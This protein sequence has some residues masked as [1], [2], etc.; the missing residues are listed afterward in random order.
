MQKPND[1]VSWIRKHYPAEWDGDEGRCSAHR[2]RTYLARKGADMYYEKLNQGSIA[3]WR[4]RQNH[5][6][7]FENGGFQGRGMKQEEAIAQAHKETEAIVTAAHKADAAKALAAGHPG[8]KVSMSQPGVTD[9]SPAP[10]RQRIKVA[11]ATSRRKGKRDEGTSTS[12]DTSFYTSQ[13]Y[14]DSSSFMGQASGSSLPLD[15]MLMANATNGDGQVDMNMVQQAL[16]SVSGGNNIDELEMGMQLPSE[17]LMHGEQ[18]EGRDWEQ[19]R[20][21]GNSGPY[22]GAQQGYAAAYGPS[23][24][25][26]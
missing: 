18:D 23:G 14:G 10:K 3:G 24:P 4:I 5:L 12:A 15:P 7:R 11:A 25:A 6:W 19:S 22:Y 9:G 2:V 16:Q 17:M 13:P 20:A 1:I 26:Q 21:Y 8:V